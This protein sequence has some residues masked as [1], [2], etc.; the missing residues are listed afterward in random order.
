MQ[1]SS[2]NLNRLNSL[3]FSVIILASV[4]TLGAGSDTDSV[5]GSYFKI[6]MLKDSVRVSTQKKMPTSVWHKACR[7]GL[8]QPLRDAVRAD[9]SKR[10]NVNIPT[11]ISYAEAN[12]IEYQSWKIQEWLHCKGNVDENDRHHNIAALAVRFAWKN[13]IKD[14][15][16]LLRSLVKLGLTDV[17]TRNE[18]FVLIA[19]NSPAQAGVDYLDQHLMFDKL[20]LEA[21][22]LSAAKLYMKFKRFD[23]ALQISATCQEPECLTLFNEASAQKAERE[24]EEASDLNSFFSAD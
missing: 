20:T 8:T 3:I 13:G 23:K 9:L 12:L 19:A 1:T 14:D 2:Y 15:E 6:E 24:R 21:S 18:A 4:E 22:R 10:L 7:Y 17:R 16:S 11:A 5:L